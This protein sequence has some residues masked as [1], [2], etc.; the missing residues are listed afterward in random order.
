MDING[1]GSKGTIL[2]LYH[3]QQELDYVMYTVLE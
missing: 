2:S 3:L 1:S